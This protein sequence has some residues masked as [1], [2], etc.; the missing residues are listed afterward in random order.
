MGHLPGR[1]RPQLIAQLCSSVPGSPPVAIER[2]RERDVHQPETYSVTSWEETGSAVGLA[3]CVY[4][5]PPTPS[6]GLPQFGHLLVPEYLVRVLG[7][8]LGF[9]PPA[10][11]GHQ[12]GHA[13]A[14][15]GRRAP[16]KHPPGFGGPQVGSA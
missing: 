2:Q 9:P 6:P 16:A 7:Y 10:V 1:G 12:R 15:M 14:G 13:S 3:L 5:L 4:F 11:S 8:H